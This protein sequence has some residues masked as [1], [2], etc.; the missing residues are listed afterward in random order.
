MFAVSFVVPCYN[1]ESFI[2]KN[3][4]QLKNKVDSLKINYEILL[5]DDGSNDKTAILLKEITKKDKHISL[6]INK[7]NTGK[8]YSVLR[9]IKKSKY[10]YVIMIDCDLPYFKSI[11]KI[12]FYLKRNIDLVIINR[13]L[14][15]SK[16]KKRQLNA[17]QLT[18]YCLGA[19]IAF[20]NKKILRLDI[21]G[22]DTQ[23]GLK[24]FKKNNHFYKNN[25]ISKK[26]F[27]D[28][29]LIHLFSKKKLKI[30][31]IKTIFDVPKK[32]SIKIFNFKNNYY[33]FKELIN[34]FKIKS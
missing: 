30:V 18:R 17:Y 10:Q 2:I 13:K 24:G 23:A 27:F 5:V 29:E 15:G 8:S 6:I 14:K 26:F 22:G 28:L 31:S 20:L 34:I 12:I 16:L 1:A 19:I 4:I 33:I 11:N 25:F 3:I 7:K 32:S 21:E 9:G